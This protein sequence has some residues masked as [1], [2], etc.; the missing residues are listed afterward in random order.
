M[1][2]E[3]QIMQLSRDS[4]TYWLVLIRKWNMV[5]IRHS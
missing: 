5:K 3:A 4:I 1:F 2:D